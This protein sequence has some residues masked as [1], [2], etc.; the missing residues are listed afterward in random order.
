[1]IGKMLQTII[2]VLGL[3]STIYIIAYAIRQDKEDKERG[4]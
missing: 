2:H 4:L 1:M 3:I